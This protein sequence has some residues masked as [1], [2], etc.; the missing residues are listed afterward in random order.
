MQKKREKE[1]KGTHTLYS[2]TSTENKIIDPQQKEREMM[3]K[4]N[5][6]NTKKQT[7]STR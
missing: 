2:V 1:N 3:M 4:E 5:Y 6:E 7:I